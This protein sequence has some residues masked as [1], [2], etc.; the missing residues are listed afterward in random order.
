VFTYMVK[1]KSDAQPKSGDKQNGQAPIDDE[2]RARISNKSGVKNNERDNNKRA[3]TCCFDD[4][5]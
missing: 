1:I 3:D 2:D 4:V 5:E